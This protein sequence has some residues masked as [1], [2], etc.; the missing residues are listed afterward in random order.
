MSKNAYKLLMDQVEPNAALIQKTKNKMIK[1]D[2]IVHKLFLRTATIVCAAVLMITATAFAA[3]YLLNPG[4]VAERMGDRTLSAAFNSENAININQSLS[5]GDYTFTL[6]SIVSGTDISDQQIMR[7]RRIFRDETY[8][9][10]AIQKSDGTPFVDNDLREGFQFYISPYVKGIAPWRLNSHLLGGGGQVII[11]EGIK[12]VLTRTDNISMFA[13]H[14]IYIG[15]NSGFLFGNAYI[16]NEE[17]GEITPNPEFDGV[18][19]LF[20]LPLDIS[21]ADPVKAQQY[22]DDLEGN[23]AE[24]D[25]I[26]TVSDIRERKVWHEE[27]R[28]I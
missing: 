8:A 19:V 12:Y 16:F 4:E 11:I 2:L 9:V 20:D 27:D 17:S 10:V 14:G 26:P 6:M 24:T 5:A 15:I 28:D 22:L 13:D 1:E 7:D 3:W 21:L 23:S 18:S 25:E